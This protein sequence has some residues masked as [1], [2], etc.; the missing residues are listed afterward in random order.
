MGASL[1]QTFTQNAYRLGLASAI[2]FVVLCL[3]Y[4]IVLIAGL[5]S[6]QS[7]QQP[8][9]DPLFSILEILIILMAPLLVTLFA[10][11][12]AWAPASEKIFSGVSLIFMSLLAGLTC[13]VHFVI[14]TLSRQEAFSELAW[15][16]FLLSFR[17]PSVVYA[18]DIL[19]W[20]GLFPLAVLFVV[21]VFYGSRLASW[22]R[23]LLISSGVLA[24]AGLGG[25]ITGDMQVRNIGIIGYVGVFPIATLLL[26]ILI[27]RTRP[28]DPSQ[29]R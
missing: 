24:L 28:G 10:A 16:P 27:Y 6:L 17:W 15:A 12:H 7:P 11:I 4:A 2:G 22:I 19:A 13:S 8:I 9:G 23:V 3:A 14:L 18:L 21:P 5:V 29:G 20:D 26:A 25:L 1:N